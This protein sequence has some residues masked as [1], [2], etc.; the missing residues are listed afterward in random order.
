MQYFNVSS[1]RISSKYCSYIF[2]TSVFKF[3]KDYV[4]SIVDIDLNDVFEAIMF[5]FIRD[6][7]LNNS[8]NIIFLSAILIY[9]IIHHYTRT[10]IYL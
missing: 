2:E 6:F 4:S 10:F 1:N 3:V 9:I 8:I 7:L 5:V